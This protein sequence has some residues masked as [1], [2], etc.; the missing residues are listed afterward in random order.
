L[1]ISE[2]AEA[3]TANAQLQTPGRAV[4]AAAMSAAEEPLTQEQIEELEGD[5]RSD[6]AAALIQARYRGNK[7]RESKGKATKGSTLMDLDSEEEEELEEKGDWEPPA[8]ALWCCTV[9]TP[10]RRHSLRI[11]QHPAFDGIV[12]LCI[13]FNSIAMAL[14]DPLEDPDTPSELTKMLHTFEIGFNCIF[15]IEMMTKIVAMGFS[16]SKGSYLRSGWNVMDFIIVV[17]S[18]LPY[19]PGVGSL[20]NASG[21]RSFRLLRPLRSISRF[22]GLKVLVETIMSAVPQLGNILLLTSMYFITFG[23]VGVQL[24][25]GVFHHR[26]GTVALDGEYLQA[27][28]SWEHHA[29]ARHGQE[30]HDTTHHVWSGNST[31]FDPMCNSTTPIEDLPDKCFHIDLA[32]ERLNGVGEAGFC[33]MDLELMRDATREER[34]LM[35]SESGCDPETERCIVCQINPYWGLISFDNIF[36]AFVIIYQIVTITSWQEYMYFTQDTSGFGCWVYY[37]I[38]TLIGAYFLFNLFVAVLKEKFDAIA[39]AEEDDS[40]SDSDDDEEHLPIVIVEFLEA[41]T[42]PLECPLE[43]MHAP[44]TCHQLKTRLSQDKFFIDHMEHLPKKDLAN[45]LVNPEDPCDRQ[46]CFNGHP[47]ADEMSLVEAGVAPGDVLRIETSA[48]RLHLKRLVQH[49]AFTTFFT[50]LIIINTIVLASERYRMPADEID[51]LASVNYFLTLSFTF[52]VMF[53]LLA[54]TPGEFGGDTFNLFD[55]FVVAAGLLE[56]LSADDQGSAAGAFRAFRIFR[57][58]RVL[59][60]LRLISFLTPLKKIGRVVMRTL[61]H[62]GYIMS[63]LLLFTYI[64]TILGM[65]AFGG[66]LELDGVVPRTNYNSFLDSMFTVT[67]ILTFDA[68]NMPLFDAVRVYG[69]KAAAYFI[70]WILLGAFVLLNLLLVII[71]DSYV[72]VAAEMKEEEERAMIGRG[73]AED[74]E[75]ASKEKLTVTEDV[76]DTFA[77]PMGANM[78]EDEIRTTIKEVAEGEEF[79]DRDHVEEAAVKLG[80]D[81]HD[82]KMEVLFM[83]G[84]KSAKVNVDG[85]VDWALEEL[86]KRRGRMRS[87]MEEVA[88]AGIAQMQLQ[89]DEAASPSTGRAGGGSSPRTPRTPKQWSAEEMAA[90]DN[91]SCGIFG[92]ENP[93]RKV[94]F[95]MS[96]SK[97]MDTFI[98]CVI[99]ANCFC[100]ALDSPYVDP[101]STRAAFLKW[102][103]VLFTFIFVGEM[104]IKVIATGFVANGETSYLRDGWNRLDFTIVMISCV[105]FTLTYILVVDGDIGIMKVFRGVRCIRPLRMLTKMRGLQMLVNS[106]VAS[107][108]SLANVFLMTMIVWLIFGILG[109]NLFCGQF[110]Y[111]TDGSAYGIEDCVGPFVDEETLQVELRRWVNQPSNF[112]NIGESMFALYEIMTLDEWIMVAYNG[113]DAVAVDKQP[114]ENNFKYVLLYFIAFIVVCN[115]LFLNLFIGVIYEEYVALKNAGLLGLTAGQKA[116]YNVQMAVSHAKPAVRAVMAKGAERG[117]VKE[118]VYKLVTSAKFDHFIMLTILANCIVMSMSYYQEPEWYTTLCNVLNYM[119]TFIFTV[120]MVLKI[121][122][123]S[124]AGYWLEAWNRFDFV[125]VMLCLVDIVVS[126]ILQV[127]SFS[128]SVFRLFRIGRVLGRV[129]RMFRVIKEVQSL[130]Q[131]FQTLVES[132]PALFYMGILVLLIIFI[133]SILGMHIFG[134]LK[135]GDVIG[136]NANFET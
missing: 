31:A 121:Y 4:A 80:I 18:W 32:D 98:L 93:L 134:R 101:E 9:N 82:D 96:L 22:P 124:F 8:T 81:P 64:F 76:Q 126:D 136:P 102:M 7:A 73:A 104:M 71:L 90:L 13:V 115:F 2:P 120:E 78:N 100:M 99:I 88:Q 112:D 37:I 133:F 75:A 63:L 52:E 12:L 95:T 57:L 62:L 33:A 42:Y 30:H 29:R 69:W 55:F 44:E 84:G 132:L 66:K 15:T 36:L 61:G 85:F 17:T 89:I 59:R 27:A 24:W 127:K 94:C 103:D 97:T 83:G 116:W 119:F 28:E 21:L 86:R 47:I 117:G 38:C 68:W 65:Q 60:V 40:R 123:L 118:T 48:M 131:I 45:A 135:H 49:S 128:S 54:Y 19:I 39:D 16:S 91:K 108:T 130:N 125:I 77:N 34:K 25:R 122:A 53:K 41:R 105:D 87:D 51:F 92:M 1:H 20:L 106:L 129:A 111:C 109:I 56:L 70:L 74:R 114:L 3:A 10:P 72:E 14:E 35:H 58:F 113:I 6:R 23:I 11:M 107:V 79:M 43:D 50:A 26:C 46:L 110:W 67:Q 5:E